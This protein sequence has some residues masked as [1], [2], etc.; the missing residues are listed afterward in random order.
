MG[1]VAASNALLRWPKVRPFRFDPSN[2]PWATFTD[3]EV[4]RVGLTEAEP[5]ARIPRLVSRSC[6]STVDRRRGGA[7][8][9]FVKLIAAPK[10]ASATGAGVAGR[11]HDRR[12]D[13]W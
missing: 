2:V 5:Q 13:R 11:R 8:R 9:G 1:W 6:R 12:A 4:G 3:P 7:E 10:R